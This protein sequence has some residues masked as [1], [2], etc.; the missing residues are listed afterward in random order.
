MLQ[1]ESAPRK[2]RDQSSNQATSEEIVHSHDSSQSDRLR[3]T[4]RGELIRNE[5][6]R[7]FELEKAHEARFRQLLQQAGG[8][9]WYEEIVHRVLRGLRPRDRSTSV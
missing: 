2:S 6:R 7:R 1:G 3:Q 9:P 4:I 8:Y 5:L